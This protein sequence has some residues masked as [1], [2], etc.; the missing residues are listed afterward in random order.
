MTCHICNNIGILQTECEL[1]RRQVCPHNVFHGRDGHP[2]SQKVFLEGADTM[3]GYGGV[4]CNE[5]VNKHLT[6]FTEY[7]FEVAA[8]VKWK[9]D[10]FFI[11][12]HND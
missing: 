10:Q 8:D 3:L 2:C 5:C 9:I 4:W 12:K 11:D 6:A 1:C 7:F